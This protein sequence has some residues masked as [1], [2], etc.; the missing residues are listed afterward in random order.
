MFGIAG[1]STSTFTDVGSSGI[2]IRMTLS[3][4]NSVHKAGYPVVKTKPAGVQTLAIGMS[5]TLADTASGMTFTIDFFETGTTNPTRVMVS[6]M[7]FY[8]IDQN[9]G[10]KYGGTYPNGVPRWRE[11]LDFSV[12]E[13]GGGTPDGTLAFPGV[14]SQLNLDELTDVVGSMD[15]PNRDDRNPPPESLVNRATISSTS[16]IQQ[17]QFDYTNNQAVLPPHDS[18]TQTE[19]FSFQMGGFEMAAIPE[20]TSLLLA[21][22]AMTAVLLRVRR[23]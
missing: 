8:D 16:F 7:K 22:L 9:D 6:D 23:G 1:D 21:L 4:P 14:G 18:N 11:Q 2:D 10:P 15:I 17:L 12:V 5:G 13:F 19:K 3:D 20:P